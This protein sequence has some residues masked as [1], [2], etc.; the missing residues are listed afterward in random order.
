M[1]REL[2]V[3]DLVAP[4]PEGARRLDAHEEVGIPEP[5]AVEEGG[6]VDDVVTAADRGLGGGGAAAQ[7]F[8][9]ILDGL[10]R[11]D[12]RDL[13]SRGFE[14]GQVALLVG[15]PALLQDV[16]LRV[17]AHR[18][19]HQARR[20]GQLQSGQV[21]AGQEPDEVRGREDGLAVD[22]LHGRADPPA[23]DD[24]DP[25]AASRPRSRGRVARPRRGQATSSDG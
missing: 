12:A 17:R 19:P 10:V 13:P 25:T 6:L 22:E 11:V 9:P 4:G 2:G 14:I 1:P 24:Q 5:A 8:A 16:E 3:H 7:P 15:E 23:G 20:R 18:P 21:L